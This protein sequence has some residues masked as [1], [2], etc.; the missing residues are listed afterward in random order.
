MSARLHHRGWTISTASCYPL[1][2]ARMWPWD[3]AKTQDTSVNQTQHVRGESSAGLDNNK[4]LNTAKKYG[5]TTMQWGRTTRY[6]VQYTVLGRPSLSLSATYDVFTA[7]YLHFINAAATSRRGHGRRGQ[8][9]YV[10]KR[11][12]SLCASPSTMNERCY[13]T[14]TRSYVARSRGPARGTK[15]RMRAHSI[16]R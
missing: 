12:E 4:N 5:N 7:T 16:K 13:R 10:Q 9:T 11:R 15:T 1:V 14:R 6:M 3:S 8:A 2:S